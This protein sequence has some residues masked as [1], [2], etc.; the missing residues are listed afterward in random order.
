MGIGFVFA[1]WLVVGSALAFASSRIARKV[2]TRLTGN[3]ADSVP[4]QKLVRMAAWFPFAC[5]AWGITVVIA[6]GVINETWRARDFG[7]GDDAHCPV[8]NG[9]NLNVDEEGVLY[10][11]GAHSSNDSIYPDSDTVWGVS[12]L[13]VT[14]P[15]ILG[16]ADSHSFN[17]SA[18][19]EPPP[20]QY[21]LLNTVTRK[22]LDFKGGDALRSAAAQAGIA[23]NLK[24]VELVYR[25]YRFTGF[26]DLAAILLFLPPIAAAAFLLRL[27]LRLKD[28]HL[29]APA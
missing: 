17:H 7:L 10:Y 24:S 16:A 23:L 27:I 3:V 11:S 26:D 8:L 6:Q 1:L 13:Q 15:W 9:W 21:F 4:K 2:A 19:T 20:D 14:G 5:L 22:R 12:K 18:L 29:E 28:V 25:R